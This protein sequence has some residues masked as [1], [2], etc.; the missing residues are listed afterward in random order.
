M[1]L[2][3]ELI[4]V[5]AADPTQRPLVAHH[6]V[7][8]EEEVERP[9]AHRHLE[10]REE[11]A[12]LGPPLVYQGQL[13]SMALVEVAEPGVDRVLGAVV[14]LVLEMAVILGHPQ[15]PIAVGVAED[16]VDGK[17]ARLAQEQRE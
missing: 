7:G 17:V 8:V 12:Q 16:V 14:V 9:Q 5:V 11:M 10:A 1:E 6:R 15:L 3:L 2:F 13:W 4:T